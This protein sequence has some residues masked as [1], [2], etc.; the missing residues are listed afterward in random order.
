LFSN[1]IHDSI[2]GGPA[3]GLPCSF[4]EGDERGARAK[5]RLEIE[6]VFSKKSLPDDN[7]EVAWEGAAMKLAK[8]NSLAGVAKSNS[9]ARRLIQQ[10]AVE[11]D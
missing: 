4:F 3:V 2:T 5:A 6:K 10:G 11:V 9:E 1:G 7:A 8:V